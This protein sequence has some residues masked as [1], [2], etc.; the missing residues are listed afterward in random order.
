[1]SVDIVPLKV[2]VYRVVDPNMDLVPISERKYYVVVGA[3]DVQYQQYN[4]QGSNATTQQVVFANIRPP[5]GIIVDK[6]IRWR[7]QI[8]IDFSN[9]NSI[10]AVNWPLQTDIMTSNTWGFRAYP[11]ANM[12]NTASVQFNTQTVTATLSQYHKYLM[13]FGS[14]PNERNRFLSGSPSFQDDVPTYTDEAGIFIL[15]GRWPFSNYTTNQIEITRAI[16]PWVYSLVPDVST[17][18]RRVKSLVLDLTEP[19]FVNPIAYSDHTQPGFPWL[20]SFN[21]NF[22]LGPSM[23]RRLFCGGFISAGN[24]TGVPPQI[25]NNAI[26]SFYTPP[27]LMMRFL[28][29][30]SVDNGGTPVDAMYITPYYFA[31]DNIDQSNILLQNFLG[32][33]DPSVWDGNPPLPYNYQSNNYTW[34][35]VP[36]TIYIF[37]RPQQS[38]LDSS[39]LGYTYPDVPPL[40]GSITVK[41]NIRNLLS[42]AQTVDLYNMT[43]FVGADSSYPEWLK[44][45]GSVIA[46]NPVLALGTYPLEASGVSESLQ[47][48]FSATFYGLASLNYTGFAAPTTLVY[49]FHVVPIYQGV[50]SI[51]ENW[52]N[53]ALGILQPSDLLPGNMVQTPHGS[54]NDLYYTNVGGSFKSFFGSIWRGLKKVLPIVGKVAKVATGIIGPVAGLLPIPGAGAIS[55][56]ANLAHQTLDAIGA[57]DAEGGR[58]RRNHRRRGGAIMSVDSLEKRL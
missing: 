56:V 22:L 26:Y 50:F 3:A 16:A 48:S 51:R 33:S 17:G 49:E 25:D 18:M 28:Q 21:V 39:P 13:K 1:M 35:I 10:P 54:W 24:T 40:C 31:D 37:G 5:S 15:G 23:P 55:T 44:Y 20:T 57:G 43:T 27:Q 7:C 58:R 42:Q 52:A 47:F 4:T 6:R 41:W 36:D 34:S 9:N 32:Y 45:N 53:T 8:N 29:P 30:Q 14:N 38:F 2:P 12:I 19:V 46:I 11:L